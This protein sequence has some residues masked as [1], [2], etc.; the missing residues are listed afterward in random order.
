MRVVPLFVV[1]V[2]IAGCSPDDQQV[3]YVARVGQQTLTDA[4][5]SQ[6]LRQAVPGQD[7]L[8]LREALVEQWIANALLYDAALR[9]NL[10]QDESLQRQL[11][12]NR[13]AIITSEYVERYL[14]E[15]PPTYS[16][17]AITEYFEQN[18]E[19]LV[20]REPY[21]RYHLFGAPN[22]PVVRQARA[23]VTRRDAD[24]DTLWQAYRRQPGYLIV[25]DSIGPERGIYATLPEVRDVV[26][27]L[28]P[29]QTS[30]VIATD[31]LFYVAR[32]LERMGVGDPAPLDWVRPEIEHRLTL[33]RRRQAARR[34]VQ[35]LRAEA[36]ARGSLHLPADSQ[37]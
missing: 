30:G 15:N 4:E 33:E 19:R 9:E 6:L 18:R 14:D 8:A 3:E 31:S 17:D 2:L 37:Q 24:P 32:V 28:S 12:Q 13:Q 7:T 35:T 20:L 10:L 16:E 36:L 34:L 29:G 1:L 26:L 25:I 23:L 27:S 11:E 22:E 5:L 21:V